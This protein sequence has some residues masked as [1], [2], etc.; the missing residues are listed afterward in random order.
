MKGLETSK[1]KIE[2]PKFI[3]VYKPEIF[4]ISKHAVSVGLRIYDL[5]WSRRSIPNWLQLRLEYYLEAG[6]VYRDH[7]GNIFPIHEDSVEKTFSDDPGYKWLSDF[8][9]QCA[10]NPN[11]DYKAK[12]HLLERF[13]ILDAALRTPPLGMAI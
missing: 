2:I 8:P 4:G 6:G 9:K 3:E 5:G 10:G 7:E 13:R 12:T 11:W 1:N